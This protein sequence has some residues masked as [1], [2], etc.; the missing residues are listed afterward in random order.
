MNDSKPNQLPELQASKRTVM[1]KLK[2]ISILAWLN[3]F[4]LLMIITILLFPGLLPPSKQEREWNALLSAASAPLLPL[5]KVEKIAPQLTFAQILH[6][7]PEA[8]PILNK[9]GLLCGTCSIARYESIEMA[10]RVYDFDIKK[11]INELDS[12]LQKRRSQLI[13]KKNTK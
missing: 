1:V 4:F 13:A 2:S 5:E 6:I 11:L 12:L 10:S 8:E 3:L 9:Y 7:L